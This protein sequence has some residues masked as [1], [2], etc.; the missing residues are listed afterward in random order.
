MRKAKKIRIVA[1]CQFFK[2]DTKIPERNAPARLKE[3]RDNFIYMSK[4]KKTLKIDGRG[5]EKKI[6]NTAKLKVKTYVV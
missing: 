3:I 5:K 2:I 4:R 6:T 1:V